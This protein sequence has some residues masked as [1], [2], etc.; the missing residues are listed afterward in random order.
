MQISEP[1]EYVIL[2]L[3]KIRPMH[4]Y[5]MFQQFEGGTPGQIVH[6]EM[7][8]MYA[9][10][11]KLERLK[12]IEAELESQGTRPPRKIFHLTPLGHDVFLQW[13]IQPVEKPRDIR[14]LFLIKL[15]FMD[16]FLSTRTAGL[17]EQQIDACQR[18][19]E[20]LEA[21]HAPE[22]EAGDG[23]FFDHIVLRSRIHQTR[24]LLDWLH[25]LQE[26][27]AETR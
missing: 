15:Y 6:L 12:F 26:E 9:F 7:S 22:E 19:L 14:I 1:A 5:E 13:L 25:E 21:K 4:G 17:V 16:R 20:H 3:L 18:F 27:L 23:A 10:L 24:S 11:K 2:G 8:Q